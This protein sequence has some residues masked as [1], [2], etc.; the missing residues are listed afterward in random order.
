MT[1]LDGVGVGICLTA[2]Y[3]LIMTIIDDR[4]NP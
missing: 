4:K 3:F 1:F 2:L